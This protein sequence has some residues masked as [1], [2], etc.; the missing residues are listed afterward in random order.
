MSNLIGALSEPQSTDFMQSSRARFTLTVSVFSLVDKLGYCVRECDDRVISKVSQSG[1]KKDGR[2]APVVWP[3]RGC[4]FIAS[5]EVH[6]SPKE[7][8]KRKD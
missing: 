8:L 7:A 3:D 1:T 5:Q 4:L 2:I 6:R